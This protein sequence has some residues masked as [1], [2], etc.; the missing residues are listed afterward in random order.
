[1]YLD[2]SLSVVQTW[3]SLWF[4][5]RTIQMRWFCKATQLV[6]DLVQ[7]FFVFVYCTEVHKAAKLFHSSLTV[8]FPT[9]TSSEEIIGIRSQ[10]VGVFFSEEGELRKTAELNASVNSLPHVFLI[11]GKMFFYLLFQDVL[12]FTDQFSDW[13]RIIQIGLLMEPCSV[14]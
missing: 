5:V 9:S 14:D 7:V 4:P 13:S 3:I 11:Y 12:T 1:M 8:K 6:F 10:N 2:T